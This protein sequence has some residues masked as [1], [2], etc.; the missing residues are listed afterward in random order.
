MKPHHTDSI[1]ALESRIA[2]AS[3][4]TVTYDAATG[5]LALT[6][7][8]ANNATG[9][10]ADNLVSIL[11]TGANTYRIA[12]AGGTDIG[13]TGVAFLDIGNV[14][15]LSLIGDEGADAFFVTGVNALKTF[16]FAGG[17][18]IDQL[19]AT[20]LAVKGAATVDFGANGGS[21]SF[22]GS[23]ASIGGD[24]TVNYGANGGIVNFSA[25]S[26]LIKG[27]VALNGGLGNDQFALTN[28]GNTSLVGKGIK[29]VG[30]DGNDSVTIDSRLSAL[31]GKSAVTGN[32]IEIDGGAGSNSLISNSAGTV[33]LKGNVLFT[34]GNDAD[35]LSLLSSTLNVDGELRMNGGAGIDTATLGGAKV[36]VKKAVTIDMADGSSTVSIGAN[37]VALGSSLTVKGTTGGDDFSISV[38]KLTTGG[39][40]SFESGAGD[41]SFS[42]DAASVLIKGALTI[43]G[44]ADA[45]TVMIQAD[46]LLSGAV[47]LDLGASSDGDQAITLSG[48]SGLAGNLKLAGTLTVNSDA[49]DGGL[50]YTDRFTATDVTVSKAVLI[51]LGSADSAVT[52]DNFSVKDLFTLTTGD[53]AD[54]VNIEQN[55]NF[56]PSIMSK[57]AVINL[58]DG[59]D[60]INIGVSSAAGSSAFVKFLAGLQV[61]GGI[62]MNTKNAF[63]TAGVN[64]F[65]VP[66]TAPVG[67]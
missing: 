14:T 13:A 28:A 62:G 34:G 23:L 7:D 65:G 22:E 1:E 56:G 16:S 37:V 17:A 9:A 48:R 41:D 25:I 58:G 38:N 33:T 51:D 55:I 31:V 49:D 40:V 10:A 52:M 47:T 50:G 12:D 29:L 32:A 42:L 11:K 15:S 54:T 5:A 43:T 3:L 57:L 27:A 36:S 64:F 66:P 19:I 4:L 26:T 35:D 18:G 24:L 63:E 60:M 8:L 2:P 53:G 44:G 39:A 61:N 20:D 30:S 21:A 67:F 59:D 6:D 45:D 46:G